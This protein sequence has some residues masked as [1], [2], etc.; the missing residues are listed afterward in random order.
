MEY[1]SIKKF[2]NK[3][4]KKPSIVNKF[5]LLIIIVLG[6]MTII[7]IDENNTGTIN[8]FLSKNN[9]SFAAI[10]NWY[11]SKIGNVLPFEGDSE[12]PVFSS[13]IEYEELIEIDYGV[14]LEVGENYLVPVLENGI[15]VFIGKK[16]ECGNTVIIK[17]TD[18]V[19][20]W[21]CN[22]ENITASI[23]DYVE[24]DEFLGE[25]IDNNLFLYF[26]KDEEVIDYKKYIN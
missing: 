23:Y 16:E 25:T 24:K 19:E 2:R 3:N 13:K 11:Q 21:Y 26:Y 12:I 18:G 14:K 15:I 20:A 22:I 5:M 8:K 10:K 1:R 9:I 6:V 7:K 4:S 17:Q